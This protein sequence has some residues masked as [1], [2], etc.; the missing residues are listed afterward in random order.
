MTSPYISVH[1]LLPLYKFSVAGFSAPCDELR[2]ELLGGVYCA[3]F[4]I[5]SVEEMS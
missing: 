2:R 4:L 5:T 3:W 1:E